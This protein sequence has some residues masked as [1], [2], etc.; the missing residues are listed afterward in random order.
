M[1]K[2]INGQIIENYDTSRRFRPYLRVCVKH[3]CFDHL[4]NKKNYALDEP[5]GFDDPP[6]EEEFTD[7]SD[8]IWARNLFANALAEMKAECN[9]KNQNQIWQVFQGEVLQPA[10]LGSRPW[11][12]EYYHLDPKTLNNRLSTAYRKLR[13]FLREQIANLQ[14]HESHESIFQIIA[15][16][17]KTP[18]ANEPIVK[19]LLSQSFSDGDISEIFLSDGLCGGFNGLFPGAE[20]GADTLQ[21]AWWAVLRTPLNEFVS[22]DTNLDSC[23]EFCIDDAIF[24]ED[25]PGKLR[26]AVQNEA[27]LRTENSDVNIQHIS[28]A[29]YTLAI[30][31]SL[32]N[33]RTRS[34]SL[35]TNQL[36]HNIF[37]CKQFG[38]LS[39]DCLELLDDALK[40]MD[41]D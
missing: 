8:V 41:E 26:T 27:K 3:F 40:V 11:G 5:V 29:L 20:H 1:S 18:L 7:Q 16:L 38:W 12:A 23:N 9:R 14:T 22:N 36:T 32:V 17:L 15:E 30:C 2:L 19:S 34:T 13:R 25:I 39:E 33:E 10:F 37:I 21:S 6:H 31:S 28:F 4:K 24:L 35:F